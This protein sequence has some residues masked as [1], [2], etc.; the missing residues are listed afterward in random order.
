MLCSVFDKMGK[1]WSNGDSYLSNSEYNC[2]SNESCYGN[3]RTVMSLY[4][5]SGSNCDGVY[6]FES[7]DLSKYLSPEDLLKIKN[8]VQYP[9]KFKQSDKFKITIDDFYNI[10]VGSAICC[11]EPWK[12]EILCSVLDRMGKKWIDG[13]SYTEDNRFRYKKQCYDNV[14]NYHAKSV[15]KSRIDKVFD[16]IDVDLTR[17][18]SDDEI[19]VIFNKLPSGAEGGYAD[20][21]EYPF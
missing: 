14:G 4:D 5:L 20:V 9:Q 18:L 16:F 17:Y 1:K 12:A 2:C 11:D 6:Q 13:V 3:S 8:N 7:V 15:Y 21:H 10:D 19:S